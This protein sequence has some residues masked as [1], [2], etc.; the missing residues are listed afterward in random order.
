MRIGIAAEGRTEP[1]PCRNGRS[2][3]QILAFA[4]K[5]MLQKVG[6]AAFRI[7]FMQGPCIDTNANGNLIGRHAVLANGIAQTIGQFTERPFLVARNVAAFIN[8]RRFTGR[9]YILRSRN[10]RFLR[11]DGLRYEQ[12]SGKEKRET[13]DGARKIGHGRHIGGTTV[14]AR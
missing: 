1:L 9:S 10:G 2:D 13:P 5:Q 12:R 6:I 4:E 8:P 7:L 11:E 3:L 14:K